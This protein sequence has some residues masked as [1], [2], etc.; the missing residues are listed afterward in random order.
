VRSCPLLPVPNINNEVFRSE[1][2]DILLDE[3]RTQLGELTLAANEG[4][5]RNLD[6]REERIQRLLE[7]G[8]TYTPERLFEELYEG[9][10]Y[11]KRRADAPAGEQTADIF[12][13]LPA[14]IL[15]L[16]LLQARART[17]GIELASVDIRAEEALEIARRYRLDWMNARA[18]LVDSWR[19]IEFNADQLESTLDIFFSGDVTDVRRTQDA[20]P[21]NLGQ[22]TGTLRASV[23]F[24]APITRLGERNTYRQALIEY[25]QARRNYYAFE[26]GIAQQLRA[27]VRQ[28][29]YN[30]LF[31]ELQR[32]AV[33]EAARQID[34]N[35][36]IRIES[37]LSGQATGATAAR[38]AVSALSD[39]LDAQ[40]AFMGIWANFEA[41]RR[42]LDLA[43]G[44]LQLDSEGLWIDPGVIN[45]EYGQIDPW[46]RRGGNFFLPLESMPPEALPPAAPEA[47]APLPLGT[48]PPTLTS[49]VPYAD[50]RTAVLNET[51]GVPQYPVLEY[52]VTEVPAIDGAGPAAQMPLKAAV[53][54]ELRP[55]PSAAT[56]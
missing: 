9:V 24:D 11:P 18:N 10:L 22:R 12:V 37:E 29:Q 45:A 13:V 48:A 34:R 33:L 39:L 20:F 21:F 19:L 1:R 31:F 6:Q 42:S 47:P 4:Y 30:Q 32:L 56:E 28:M 7:E 8:M 52:P 35:E 14:D 41:D 2:L 51:S 50:V 36:D 49:D 44:T 26:D 40:N 16:Q 54:S 5:Q 46:L 53:P 38:D 27:R 15:T 3:L 25:Q 55:P 43:L 17:E 23:Q